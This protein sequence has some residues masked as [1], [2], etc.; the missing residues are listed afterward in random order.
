MSQSQ[1]IKFAFATFEN[2]QSIGS[3]LRGKHN[4]YE[5]RHLELEGKSVTVVSDGFCDVD[6]EIQS[7]LKNAGLQNILKLQEL[8]YG[9]LDNAIARVNDRG[10]Y[11]DVS[12]IPDGVGPRSAYV[13]AAQEELARL[14]ASLGLTPEEV[15]KLTGEQIAARYQELAAAQTAAASGSEGGAE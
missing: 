9:T 5:K 12:N 7:E 14:A 1:T 6:K 10:V 4:L 13:A 15:A 8:R 3:C 2:P 11:A